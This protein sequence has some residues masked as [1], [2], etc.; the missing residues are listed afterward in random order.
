MRRLLISLLVLCLPVA[1]TA[2]TAC[3][4]PAWERFKTDLLSDDGRVL[5]RSDARLISTSEG[6]SYALFFALV[7]NDRAT[8]AKVLHWTADNLADGDLAGHLPAWLWGRDPAGKWQVLDRNNASDADLWI[9]YS[10]LEAGRLWQE[11]AYA[12]LG[13]RL[14]WRIA[15]Q[16]VRK[17]PGLGLMLLPGDYGFDDQHGWRLNPSYLPPQLFDRFALVDPVWEEMARNVRQLWLQASPNGLAPDWLLWTPAAGIAPDPQHATRGSYDAIRVYL[18]LGMLAEGSAR[19]DA[20]LRHF[21]PMLAL[22]LREGM[23][24]ES[25]DTATGKASGQGPVGFS[26]ALLPLL[27]TTVDTRAALNA[28]RARL[29]A[30]PAE[31]QAY[32][33]SVLAMYGQGWGEGRYRFDKNGRMQPAWS[34]PCSE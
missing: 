5:D 28:Q 25:L 11:P 17:L 14:L 8:F 27:A 24:P 19:R 29:R 12:E 2:S 20:L 15:A 1:A 3:T 18:W 6:Q 32:Y 7:G 30:Q 33:N 34:A 9:A 10:L 21:A 22:T 23:P 31:P 26:A 16:T 4:W 13:Q